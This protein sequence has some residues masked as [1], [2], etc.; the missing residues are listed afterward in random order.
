M[1]REITQIKK[2][3]NGE[4][5]KTKKAEKRVQSLHEQ[6]VKFNKQDPAK[7]IQKVKKKETLMEKVQEE[8]EEI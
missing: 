7:L 1:N 4:M 3:Y 2:I 8:Y 5:S 6:I